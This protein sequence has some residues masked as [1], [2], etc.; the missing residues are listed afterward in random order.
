MMAGYTTLRLTY[1]LTAAQTNVYAMSGLSA[2]ALSFPA[3]FQVAAPFGSDKG[4]V[5]PL[6]FASKCKPPWL[7]VKYNLLS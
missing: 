3:A 6:F 5:N 2:Q 4:G 7:F 1:A